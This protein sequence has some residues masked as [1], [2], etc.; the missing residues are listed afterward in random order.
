MINLIILDFHCLLNEKCHDFFGSLSNQIYRWWICF[1]CSQTCFWCPT[2]VTYIMCTLS[3]KTRLSYVSLSE[4]LQSEITTWPS[5]GVS[6]WR[7]T[8][9]FPASIGWW[10]SGSALAN[11]SHS[12]RPSSL[13]G[14]VSPVL[15]DWLKIV[16]A[17][18]WWLGVFKY[19]YQNKRDSTSSSGRVLVQGKSL[20]S[21]CWTRNWSNKCLE[22]AQGS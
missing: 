7:H 16:A 6:N 1:Y 4:S 5:V 12:P 15:L 9:Q 21:V 14:F 18:Y 20:K 8:G 2:F 10:Q 13:A 17:A 3:F 11:C 19:S 22:S